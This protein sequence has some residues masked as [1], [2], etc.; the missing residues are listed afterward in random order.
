[1]AE[2]GDEAE[3][4]P[5]MSVT[6]LGSPP[7][8]GPAGGETREEKRRYREMKEYHTA[9]LKEFEVRFIRSVYRPGA[10]GGAGNKSAFSLEH[11]AQI[12]R[13]TKQTIWKIIKR[14]NWSK[15]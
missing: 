3:N 14:E 10:K 5:E 15:I 8:P 12:F 1:M 6:L 7:R 11:L 4:V 13:V 9:K 2:I